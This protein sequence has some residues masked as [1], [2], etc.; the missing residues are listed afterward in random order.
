MCPPQHLLAVGLI[1]SF[2]RDWWI[3]GTCKVIRKPRPLLCPSTRKPAR[4][5]NTWRLVCYFADSWLLCC[6]AGPSTLHITT[7]KAFGTLLRLLQG[8][9]GHYLSTDCN[10]LN[11]AFPRR[12]CSPPHFQAT[13]LDRAPWLL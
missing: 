5:K 12:G 2:R 13:S 1:H 9:C 11:H 7:Q 6:S 4:N 3:C 8:L 10:T